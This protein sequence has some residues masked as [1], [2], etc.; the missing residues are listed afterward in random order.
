MFNK[1]AKIL[2][3]LIC[4]YRKLI[5]TLTLYYPQTFIQ[6]VSEAKMKMLKFKSI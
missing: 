5:L 2:D 6:E 3:Q 1:G 4:I